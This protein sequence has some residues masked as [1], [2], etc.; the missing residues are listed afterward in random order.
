MP[1]VEGRERNELLFNDYR[2]FILP[3]EKSSRD[4]LW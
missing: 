3:N 4:V 1:G 2:V